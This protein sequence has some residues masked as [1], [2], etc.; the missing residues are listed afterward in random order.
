M[1]L[2]KTIDCIFFLLFHHLLF[3]DI[4]CVK[5]KKNWKK[6]AD[7]EG[8]KWETK[9]LVFFFCQLKYYL[10]YQLKYCHIYD[11]KKEETNVCKYLSLK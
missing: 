10:K 4:M 7:D 9:E 1:F 3:Q 5:R 2:V 11:L 8:K 6:N